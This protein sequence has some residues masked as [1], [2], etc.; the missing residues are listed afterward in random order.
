MNR[1]TSIPDARYAAAEASHAP[2]A[3]AILTSPGFLLASGLLLLNDWVLKPAVGGW[4]T[5]KLSDFAG[6]YAFPLFWCAF[7]PRRRRTVFATTAVGFLVWKSSLSAPLLDLCPLPSLRHW[8]R[9]PGVSVHELPGSS[10]WS[11]WLAS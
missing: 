1:T 3:Q 10:A 9:S 5:G 4:W 7:F 11:P 8:S 6:L 2:R